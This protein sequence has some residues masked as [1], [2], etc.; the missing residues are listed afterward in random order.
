VV[1]NVSVSPDDSTILVL[2]GVEPKRFL[3]LERGGSEFRPVFHKPLKEAS[4]WPTPLGFLNQGGLAYYLNEKGL[5]LLDPHSPSQ[6]VILPTG[7]SVQWIESLEEGALVTFIDGQDGQQSLRV[8]S[9]QGT[10]L[11]TLPLAAQDLL[12][13]RQNA[14]LLLGLDQ[15]LLRLEVRI[16]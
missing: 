1:Y 2:A 11:L 3:V 13:Q 15:T 9:P 12:L 16:Q 8:A 14:A 5:A 10:S 6:E 7:N 4:P